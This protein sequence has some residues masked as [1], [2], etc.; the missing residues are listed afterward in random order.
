MI[1]VREVARVRKLERRNFCKK[2]C[3]LAKAFGV[4]VPSLS[5][6]VGKRTASPTV[7]ASRGEFVFESLSR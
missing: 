6:L 5:L 2:R 3:Q 7:G 1:R 4:S